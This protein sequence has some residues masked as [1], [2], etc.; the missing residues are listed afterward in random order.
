LVRTSL[1]KNH[2]TLPAYL[3][4]SETCRRFGARSADPPL[5]LLSDAQGRIATIARGGDQGT[6]HRLEAQVQGWLE[7][8]D[9]MED[10]RFAMIRP[11]DVVAM[12]ALR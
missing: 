2:A 3:A 1:A 11:R 8:L 9:P 7:E 4:S 10:T 6:I 12:Q 5:H